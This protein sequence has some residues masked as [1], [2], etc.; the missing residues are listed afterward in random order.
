MMSFTAAQALGVWR[1]L[2]SSS[3]PTSPPTGRRQGVVEW[4]PCVAFDLV[5]PLDMQTPGAVCGC[6]SGGRVR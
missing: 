4:Q 6:A 3:N 2:D 1:V 5:V